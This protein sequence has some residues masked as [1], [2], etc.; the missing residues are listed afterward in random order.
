MERPERLTAEFVEKIDR[1]GR[2]TDGKGGNGLTLLVRPRK[3][4][5]LAKNWAQHLRVRGNLRSLGLGTYPGVRLVE[6]RRLAADNAARVRAAFPP[7]RPRGIDRL[8]AEA[9]G[10]DTATTGSPAVLSMTYPTFNAVAEEALQ[11]YGTKW[12]G[13]STLDQRR[14]LG[15]KYIAPVIGAMPVDQVAP[16]DIM[17]VLSPTWNV[18]MATAKKVWQSLQA[19]VN[20][21][22]GMGYIIDDPMPR[23]KIGLGRQIASTVHHESLPHD[24]VG[25]LWQYLVAESSNAS[26][27]LQLLV[28]TG[29]RSGEARGA[30][31]AEIDFPNATWTIPGSRMK[32]GE[33]HRIP[34]SAAALDVLR[35]VKDTHDN[36]IWYD[37]LIF[38]NG[39]GRPM[40]KET[41]QRFLRRGVSGSAATIHGLR[42]TLDVWASEMTDYPAEIVNHALAHL[43]GDA[44]IRAYRRTDYFDKRRALMEEWADYVTGG[45]RVHPA[46][47]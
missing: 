46:D 42:T 4:G 11:H 47:K 34:L 10:A 30:R 20:Y 27:C 37:A 43:K 41:L 19:T 36:R 14:A 31:W 5:S 25:E 39:G 18:K 35:R 3:D 40:T 26:L 17:R 44:T 13:T 32:A 15:G 38:P 23:A 21:A 28:L 33:E 9:A 24:R 7:R 16:E 2:Y 8:L 22:I 12:K 29:V 6:S 45:H 1:P